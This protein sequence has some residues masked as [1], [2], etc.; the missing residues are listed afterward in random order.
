VPIALGTDLAGR[1]LYGRNL[2]EIAHLQRAGLSVEEALLAATL[3]GA[4]LCGVADRLG[5]MAPGQRFDALLLDEAPAGPEFFER[6]DA[7]RAVFRAGVAVV[8]HAR[9][10]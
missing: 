2:I 9:F 1:E 7:V 8:P 10:A 5:R 3:G 6:P 4:R